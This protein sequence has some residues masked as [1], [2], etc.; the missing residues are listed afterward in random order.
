MLENSDM[1]NEESTFL[2]VKGDVDQRCLLLGHSE[3]KDKRIIQLGWG[4]STLAISTFG[5]KQF[6]G[7]GG[8]GD[9]PV[10][11]KMFT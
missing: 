6:I 11:C 2:R 9:C 7:G 3:R 4:F 5:A 1:D 10:H 8:G